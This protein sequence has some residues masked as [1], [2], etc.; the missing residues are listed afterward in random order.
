MNCIKMS[1]N[2][3]QLVSS[4]PFKINE[5]IVMHLQWFFFFWLSNNIM[6]SGSISVFFF[7]FMRH[8]RMMMEEKFISRIAWGPR[9]NVS[10]NT[11]LLF[12]SFLFLFYSFMS[13][14]L[15]SF[16]MRT[17]KFI[18][19]HLIYISFFCTFYM[20]QW[21]CLDSYKC[22]CLII[23]LHILRKCFMCLRF[24]KGSHLVVISNVF[25]YERL[26]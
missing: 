20:R 23:I 3:S 9:K 16:N 6:E 4:I 13:W 18:T 22:V 7:D 2:A 10:L 8:G 25:E 24:L 21:I 14:C 15:S 12:H 26:L 17:I 11:I 5:W 19:F 1:S